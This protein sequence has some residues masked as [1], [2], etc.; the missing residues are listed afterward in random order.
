MLTHLNVTSGLK[1]HL[2]SRPF[3]PTHLS[4]SGLSLQNLC[5]SERSQIEDRTFIVQVVQVKSQSSSKRRNQD[6]PED[7]A[8]KY[9][10][11]R[12]LRGHFAFSFEEKG[13]AKG[14]AVANNGATLLDEIQISDGQFLVDVKLQR[15]IV[16]QLIESDNMFKL[17]SVLVIKGKVI[18]RIIPEK[19]KLQLVLEEP[20]ILVINDVKPA[21]IGNP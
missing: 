8:Q 16:E 10:Q 1:T 13:S 21:I 3:I 18:R 9:S 11:E 14:H 15:E 4:P 2:F 7:L 17:Y 5:F 12:R 20:P 19:V 6:V